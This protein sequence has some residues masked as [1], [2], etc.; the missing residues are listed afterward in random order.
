M[1]SRRSGYLPLRLDEEDVDD[2]DHEGV[3]EMKDVTHSNDDSSQEDITPSSSS[4][5]HLKNNTHLA[6]SSAGMPSF[7]DRMN[8]STVS[9]SGVSH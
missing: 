3:F 7:R 1:G 2:L 5:K 8:P 9:S 6:P 4:T